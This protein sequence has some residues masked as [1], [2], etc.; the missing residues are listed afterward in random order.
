MGCGLLAGSAARAQVIPP[1]ATIQQTPVLENET[2]SGVKYDNKYEIYGGPAYTHFNP[3]PSL[4]GGENMGGFD[5]QGTRWLTG[6]YGVTANLRG[7]YGTQ[8][9]VP[10]DLNIR[11]PFIIQHQFLGGATMRGVENEHIAIDFHALVG[12]SYGFFSSALNKGVSPQ[13]LGLFPNGVVLAGAFGASLDLNRSSQV[14]LRI[15]PDYLQTRFGGH[16]Q[17]E[18]AVS[19]G[20]LY[21]FAKKRQSQKTH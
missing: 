13:S 6:R 2:L 19:V 12:G 15:S 1:A 4:V 9:V 18:F 11:G 8:G 21:R 20:I 16:P 17:N 10:N 14:A 7:Y 3:G 5:I